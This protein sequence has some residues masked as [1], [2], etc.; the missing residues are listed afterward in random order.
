[1]HAKGLT[2]PYARRPGAPVS[3]SKLAEMLAN[4]FYIGVV[5]WAGGTPA[6]TRRWCPQSLFDRSRRSGG[7]ATSPDFASA[8]TSTT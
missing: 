4:P 7:P 6:S 1:M 2:S 3:V 8:A 5:Q